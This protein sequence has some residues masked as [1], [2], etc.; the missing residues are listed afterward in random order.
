VVVVLVLL[1]FRSGPREAGGLRQTLAGGALA[2]GLWLVT[3]VGFAFYA[4]HVATYN[5]LYG[6][7]AGMVVL[8][9]WLWVSHVMLLVGAQFN[10]ELSRDR[11]PEGP[12]PCSPTV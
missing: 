7:L 5:R 9:V 2:V 8:L 12:A 10:V 4:S 6:S 1:L 11:R 3:S